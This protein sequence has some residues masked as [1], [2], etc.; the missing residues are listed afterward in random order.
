MATLGERNSVLIS[1]ISTLIF[2]CLTIHAS[3]QEY[4]VIEVARG[5]T[6]AGTVKW[7]G[8]VPPQVKLPVSKDPQICDPEG[9]KSRDLERLVIGPTGG[10]ANTVVFLKQVTRGKAWDIPPARQTVDQR[11][12]RYEPHIMLVPDNANLRMKSSDATLHTL[13]MSGA[14]NFNIAFPFQSQYI[15]REM[16]HPGV[17][18]IKCN[19]GHVWMNGELLVVPHPYY[20]VTDE[21][22]RFRLTNVPPGEY[23]IE[24]WHEGWRVSR[25]EAVLDVG[26]QVRVHRPVYSAPKTWEKQVNVPPDGEVNVNFTI[27][28]D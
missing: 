19:A 9:K 20:A 3:A 1:V 21:Q 25:D 22:G 4:Q 28:Q 17:V 26:A 27:S 13:H 2:L 15:T 23:T 14:E 24:A 12:C 18:D 5:G 7:S 8:P 10:I 6:I 11:T 16:T